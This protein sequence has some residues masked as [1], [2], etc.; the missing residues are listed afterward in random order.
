MVQANFIFYTGLIIFV[1]LLF[2]SFLAL[3]T[4]KRIKNEAPSAIDSKKIYSSNN[5]FGIEK[6][7]PEKKQ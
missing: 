7:K 1:P 2:V 5:I 6:N 4:E 3:I